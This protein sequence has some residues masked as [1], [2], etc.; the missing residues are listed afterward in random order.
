MP[1]GDSQVYE[2]TVGDVRKLDNKL[3]CI[4]YEIREIKS[5]ISSKS[6]VI[7]NTKATW[8]WKTVSIVIGSVIAT[9]LLAVEQ[10]RQ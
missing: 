2:W 6:V 4:S 7:D 10:I 3:D 5:A 8:D 9:I 1:N